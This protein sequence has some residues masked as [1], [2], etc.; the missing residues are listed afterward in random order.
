MVDGEL[1]TAAAATSAVM[2]TV[3]RGMAGEVWERIRK[4]AI[5]QTGDAAE[6]WLKKVVMRVFGQS[7]LPADE[8]ATGPLDAEVSQ[9]VVAALEALASR[10]DDD[11]SV[12]LMTELIMKAAADMADPVGT[13]WEL[14]EAAPRPQTAAD[15]GSAGNANT[16]DI[17]QKDVSGTA[18]AV[19][20]TT[21]KITVQRP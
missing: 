12:A 18:I 6:G 1:A 8:G 19:T 9:E 14:A 13:L 4:D 10:P 3:L 5:E 15:R 11:Q 7:K 17:K 2:A 21:G 16:G 20:G